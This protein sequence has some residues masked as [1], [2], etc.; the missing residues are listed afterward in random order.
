VC[1]IKVFTGIFDEFSPDL[2]RL[3]ALALRLADPEP[4]D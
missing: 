4:H 3:G 1:I 2:P